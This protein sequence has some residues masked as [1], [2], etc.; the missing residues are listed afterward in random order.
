MRTLTLGLLLL[1]THINLSAMDKPI[2]LKP[3]EIQPRVSVSNTFTSPLSIKFKG[4]KEFPMVVLMSINSTLRLYKEDYAS[5]RTIHNELVETI[6]HGH[7][8][9]IE[10]IKK[11][12]S[13][14]KFHKD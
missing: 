8:N 3:V 14:E 13:Y 1:N 6:F 11:K 7:P 12:L 9:L 5:K 10:H 4:K 2:M